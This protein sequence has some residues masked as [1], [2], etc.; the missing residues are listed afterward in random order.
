ML[1]REKAFL[2]AQQLHMPDKDL[3]HVEIQQSDGVQMRLKVTQREFYTA[4]VCAVINKPQALVPLYCCE[5]INK[6]LLSV[7]W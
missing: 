5:E 6:Q 2:V 4:S 3:G 1:S 7:K